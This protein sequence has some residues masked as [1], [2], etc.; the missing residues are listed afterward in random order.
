M[1]P[2]PGRQI[3]LRFSVAHG[4]ARFRPVRGRDAAV[5]AAA[6]C[7]LLLLAV[8]RSLDPGS[9]PVRPHLAVA[10]VAA[11]VMCLARWWR[12]AIPW[13]QS[14]SPWLACRPARRWA[15]PH[16]PGSSRCCAWS[17]TQ[18]VRTPEAG[19]LLRA[20][21]IGP[22]GLGNRPII[23]RRVR[24][25]D[26]VWTVAMLGVSW[27]AAQGYVAGRRPWPRTGRLPGRTAGAD[28]P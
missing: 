6:V 1:G 23:G 19:S 26:D 9:V 18:P 3:R 12:G 10:L 24:A 8:A 21:R 15:S 5:D 11:S 20:L 16:K 4:A 22:G 28:G 17:P 7:G 27:A 14:S 13:Y 2:R 25:D